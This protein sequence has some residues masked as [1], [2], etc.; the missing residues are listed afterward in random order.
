MPHI[1]QGELPVPNSSDEFE[2]IVWDVY[3]RRWKDPSA[4]RYGSS[5]QAQQGVDI[6]GRPAGLAGKYVGVQCK[7]YR[8]GKLTRA[9]VEEEIAKA[10]E[11]SPTLAEYIIATTE[12][13]DAKLQEAVR[14]IDGGPAGRG[15][16]RG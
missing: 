6:Y 1:P 8:D 4:K 3:S 12:H 11:F 9:K 2:D 7:R 13:R 16:V 5:G 10:E 14:E 15:Q